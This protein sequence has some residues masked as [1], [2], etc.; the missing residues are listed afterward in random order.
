MIMKVIR[1]LRH[2]LVLL[3]LMLLLLETM[4]KIGDFGIGQPNLCLWM[5]MCLNEKGKSFKGFV[6]WL[7]KC[8]NGGNSYPRFYLKKAYPWVP[9]I[10]CPHKIQTRIDDN[11]VFQ[12]EIYGQEDGEELQVNFAETFTLEICMLI[13]KV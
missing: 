1:C 8:I 2:P 7:Q 5:P 11:N 3:I 6:P 12:L 4:K 13:Q 9:G 10:G